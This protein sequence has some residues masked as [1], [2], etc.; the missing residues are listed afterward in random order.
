ML[1]LLGAY[2]IEN[3]KIRECHLQTAKPST[4]DQ[5]SCPTTFTVS[6]FSEKN[7][8]LSESSCR[9][10][11]SQPAN[12]RLLNLAIDFILEFQLL[13][14]GKE[15]RGSPEILLSQNEAVGANNEK[16]KERMRDMIP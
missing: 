11:S 5:R 4:T 14:L 10:K 13:R 2:Q 6:R 15:M 9:V 3:Q 7:F 12:V 16:G 1:S 8:E